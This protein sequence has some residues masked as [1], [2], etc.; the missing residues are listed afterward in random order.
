M[1]PTRPG[2]ATSEVDN[3]VERTI[4]DL[5]IPPC[6]AILDRFMAEMSKDEP[7][8]NR[9]ADLICADVGISAG[10]IKTANSPFF[11]LRQRVRSG[12]EALVMLGLNTT[13]RAIA[14]I[15]LRK[16][17]PN[18]P[19]LERFWD[20]SARISY[21]SG[22]LAKHL[23]IRGLR[24]VDAHTFGLFCDCGIP[25]LLGR[26]KN[27]EAVLDMA[28]RDSARNFTDVEEEEISAN[29]AMV[30]ELL[31]RSWGLPE[32]ICLAIS[33]H[34]DLA[35]LETA[36]AQL[37]LLSKRLIATAQL[38]E[39]LMQRQLGISLSREWQRLGSAC[40]RLL[41]LAEEQLEELYVESEGII[42]TEE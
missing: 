3:F 16:S 22:W 29:H 8:Y 31:A 10:L 32:E 1:N 12:G 11:S 6:P 41:D 35:Q 30:G 20:S 19:N 21:L 37:P 15:A 24:T 34:H 28:N 9:L 26:F 25:V 2:S 18:T 42:A 27:Y 5:G 14:G 36:A 38:A 17:F 39:Y 33:N 13:S 4:L 40:L 7:D 23:E